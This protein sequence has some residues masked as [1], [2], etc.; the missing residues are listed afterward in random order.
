VAVRGSVEPVVRVKSR[1]K[2]SSRSSTFTLNVPFVSP[3]TIQKPAAFVVARH[4]VAQPVP[5]PLVTTT[6]TFGMPGSP[7]SCT[8]SLSTSCQRRLPIEKFAAGL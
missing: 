6:S 5:V 7:G 2:S 3:V 4:G 8:P 1:G